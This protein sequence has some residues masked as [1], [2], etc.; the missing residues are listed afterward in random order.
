MWKLNE[1][2][3]YKCNSESLFSTKT[4]VFYIINFFRYAY[5]YKEHYNK[6]SENIKMHLENPINAF[7]FIRKLTTTWEQI[8]EISEL[9]FGFRES[10]N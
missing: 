9:N 8:K 10:K 1:K 3:F 2:N 6:A 7:I 5:K 4:F